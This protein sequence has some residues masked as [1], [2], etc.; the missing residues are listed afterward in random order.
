MRANADGN[1][2]LSC[3]GYNKALEL[4]KEYGIVM[5]CSQAVIICSFVL[6][7]DDAHCKSLAR[8]RK[9]QRLVCSLSLHSTLVI[10]VQYYSTLD[11]IELLNRLVQYPTSLDQSRKK[12]EAQIT[13][14]TAHFIIYTIRLLRVLAYQTTF[15]W[16]FHSWLHPHSKLPSNLRTV[17]FKRIF[18]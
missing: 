18:I 11:N 17:K 2:I 7:N 14:I 16:I 3:V 8:L 5:V 1:R 13:Q 6:Q 4:N 15:I 12:M 10:H 9:Q